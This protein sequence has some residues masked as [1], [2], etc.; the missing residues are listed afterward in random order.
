[1]TRK[2][3]PSSNK[4]ASAHH[5]Y[6]AYELDYYSPTFSTNRTDNKYKV[7]IKPFWTQGKS[8]GK[9]GMRISSWGLWVFGGQLGNWGSYI[10]KKKFPNNPERP[11][12]I[13]S[14]M[15]GGRCAKWLERCCDE[16]NM[17]IEHDKI[18]TIDEIVAVIPQF[19]PKH[20]IK[21]KRLPTKI[22]K[23]AEEKKIADF[24]ALLD[25]IPVKKKGKF[26]PW[27]DEEDEEEE[28]MAISADMPF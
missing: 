7:E 10:S 2:Y 19:I 4:Y 11:I 26:I 12:M 16:I 28:D 3:S 20:T 6:N 8:A 14:V 24:Q 25:S 13:Y 15:S 17:L 5:M 22:E 23:E 1:M 18:S 27:E 9:G 21:E